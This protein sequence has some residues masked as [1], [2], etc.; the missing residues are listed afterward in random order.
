LSANFLKSISDLAEHWNAIE[1]R[2]KEAEQLRGEP[3]IPSINELR[4]AGRQMVDAWAIY[5]KKKISAQERQRFNRCVT[6][7][8][9]YL[10]NADHDITDSICFFIHRRIQTLLSLYSKRRLRNYYPEIDNL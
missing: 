7:A 2:L 1:G 8:K 10:F 5:E 3:V 6:V 4:Y 9:Q